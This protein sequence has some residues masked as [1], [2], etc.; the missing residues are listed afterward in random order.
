MGGNHRGA[1]FRGRELNATDFTRANLRG[2]DFIDA[3]LA[4]AL[5]RGADLRGADLSRANLA[6]A[7]L[8][9]ARVGLRPLATT[10]LLGGALLLAG[11]AGLAVG[12]MSED[13]RDRA[14]S[15]EAM[16]TIGAGMALLLLVVFIAALAARGIKVALVAFCVSL[17]ILLVVGWLIGTLAFD[18]YRPDAVINL[19]AITVVIAAALV[20]GL[21]GRVVAGTWGTVATL[22]VAVA[23]GILTGGAGGGLGA[24]AVSVVIAIIAKRGLADLSTDRPIHRFAL[25]IVRL[26]G[27]RFIGADLRGA[28]LTGVRLNHC[29]LED[30]QTEGMIVGPAPKSIE[31][32]AADQGSPMT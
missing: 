15:P 20:A 19:V 8:R 1:S 4:G 3:Q 14:T 28:D 25:R 12:V 6:G 24:T 9:E 18:T 22:T 32:P 13:L 7:D 21:L 26:R 5:F 2:A 27:T 17:L 11:V 10:L 30:A 23:A 31:P 29:D 16:D